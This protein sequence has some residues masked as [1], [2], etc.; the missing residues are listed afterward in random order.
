M[1]I[2]FMIICTCIFTLLVSLAGILNAP[3]TRI[4]D[5]K[6]TTTIPPFSVQ[7]TTSKPIYIFIIVVVVLVIL[8]SIGLTTF[9]VVVM[10]RRR[11]HKRVCKNINVKEMIQA[12]SIHDFKSSCNTEV[13]KHGKK[14][15]PG[16]IYNINI[17]LFIY[18]LTL[19]SIVQCSNDA[20]QREL[21]G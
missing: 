10:V 7:Q 20:I 6:P 21:H 15:L 3:K 13:E 1:N 12:T 2:C 4:N 16:K 11:L 17:Y 8:L 19:I 9:V 18:L 5:I 14:N